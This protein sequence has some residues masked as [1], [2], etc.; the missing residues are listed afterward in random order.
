MNSVD[1]IKMNIA[2][3]ELEALKGAENTIRNYK[4]KLAISSYHRNLD[5]YTIPKFIND[6]D[7]GY[8]F[9]IGH[10]TPNQS[11]TVLFAKIY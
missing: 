10:A 9:Y 5:F 6:L 2:G 7:L 3:D 11:E 1:F 4:P 8:K